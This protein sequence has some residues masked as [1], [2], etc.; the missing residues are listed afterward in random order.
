MLPY[1]I[2]Q[3]DVLRYLGF[4]NK[5]PDEVTVEQIQEISQLLAESAT[6][7][8]TYSLIP[9]DFNSDTPFTGTTFPLNSADL[10]KLLQP[11]THAI[12]M[13][14]T[15]GHPVDRLLRQ[16]QLRDMS[17]A[18]ILDACASS[19]VEEYCNYYE[20]EL[21]T[22]FPDQFFTDRFSPGYGDLPLALQV[23]FCAILNTEKTLGLS[24]SP[25]QIMAPSKSITAILGVADSPQ[26]MRIKGCQYC[27]LRSNCPY[28]KGGKTCGS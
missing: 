24:L 19:L 22:Q 25:T 8:A 15:L 1:T 27:Q 14:V 18:L 4:G 17:K 21:K 10:T 5:K 11:C 16:Y 13:A 28:R 26:P 9:L 6:P 7:H 12:F 2:K 20:G 23:P 3:S